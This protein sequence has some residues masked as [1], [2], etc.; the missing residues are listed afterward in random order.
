ME[1]KKTTE[2]TRVMLVGDGPMV[3]TGNFV[4]KS[5]EQTIELT[6]AQRQSGVTLCRCGRSSSMP[7]CDGS[8]VKHHR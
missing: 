1:E 5:G 4:L 7:Y 3:V 8:H 2:K 6:D